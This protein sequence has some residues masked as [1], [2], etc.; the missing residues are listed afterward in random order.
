MNARLCID[1]IVSVAPEQLS[2]ALGDESAI[3]N[4]K[5]SVYY[6]LDPVGTRIWNLMQQPMSVRELRDRLMDEYE[7][8]A[9]RCEGDLLSLLE[10]MRS[11]GLI[12]VEGS[13]RG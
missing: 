12:R 10:T 5:N 4:L 2:C 8:D 3:L 13:D 11:E 7:V 1:S 9:D 6:G